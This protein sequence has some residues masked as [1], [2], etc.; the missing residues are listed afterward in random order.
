MTWLLQTAWLQS[1]CSYCTV[2]KLA[3]EWKS[4]R[5]CRYMQHPRLPQDVHV[6]LLHI[7]VFFFFN[8]ISKYMH[9]EQRLWRFN[10]NT[11]F[12]CRLEEFKDNNENEGRVKKRSENIHL[13]GFVGAVRKLVSSFSS[14]DAI[15]SVTA[16][17][18]LLM[19]QSSCLSCTE[20][21]FLGYGTDKMSSW[22]QTRIS[23]DTLLSILCSR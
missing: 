8:V 18:L 11:V 9:L 22:Q 14:T 6:Q 2:Q 12:I 23:M 19:A 17:C 15:G 1:D 13:R 21:A 4:N 3:G 10:T 7:C 16:L 5:Y 20:L